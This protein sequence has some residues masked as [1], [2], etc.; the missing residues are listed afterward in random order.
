MFAVCL[1]KSQLLVKQEKLDQHASDNNHNNE[2]DTVTPPVYIQSKTKKEKSNGFNHSTPVLRDLKTEI[3]VE[4]DDDD[5]ESEYEENENKDH[6]SSILFNANQNERL[7]KYSMYSNNGAGISMDRV[8]PV[9]AKEKKNFNLLQQQ[10][11]QIN[12][13]QQQMY[14]P[15]TVCSVCGDRASGKHYGV[16]SC[17][18]CRGFFKRSIR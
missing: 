10:Q 16:L 9:Y 15:V 5:E 2:R 8:M 6:S 11:Q 4:D 13:S 7:S 18:G 17:D 1:K 14:K 12:Q 3:N